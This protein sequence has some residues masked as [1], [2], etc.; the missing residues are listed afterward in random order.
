MNLL[1]KAAQVLPVENLWVNPDCGSKTRGWAEVQLSR[2]FDYR[3]LAELASD[4]KMV[5]AGKTRNVTCAVAGP[6]VKG[7]PIPL[8]AAV[9]LIPSKQLKRFR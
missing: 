3:R 4:G 1:A 5:C 7:A 8:S 6:K 9:S 2:V